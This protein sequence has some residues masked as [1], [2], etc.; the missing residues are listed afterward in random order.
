MWGADKT[1]TQIADALDC[2]RDMVIGKAHR[3]N[4]KVRPSPIK[5]DAIMAEKRRA[6]TR[7]R[8]RYHFVNQ[9][10]EA[11]GLPPLPRPA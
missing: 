5:A 8:R 10:R 4:L 2:T 6:E 7:E 9:R 11:K 1:A 3:L